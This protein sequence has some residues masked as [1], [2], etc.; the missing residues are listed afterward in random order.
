MVS[1]KVQVWLPV[2]FAVLMVCG[3]I[4][5]YELRDKTGGSRFLSAG[6]RSSLQEVLDLV[7]ERY[8]DAIPSDSLGQVAI[9]EVLDHLDPHSV[10]IPAS[11]L[12]EMDE[13]LEGNFQGIGIEFQLIRD[14][15]NIVSIISGG[16]SEKAGLQIGD[17]LLRAND[18]VVLAGVN[19]TTD[20]IRRQLRGAYDSP[21]KLTILRNG[22][23][24]QVTIKRGMIHLLMQPTLLPRRQVIYASTNLQSRLT[25]NS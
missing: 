17:Q 22:Q 24:K 8:V 13:Q 12:A 11:N 19:I 25:W 3:M 6:G 4:I 20:G 10:Y 21:V 2:L 5:G 16:P 1:K 14:T 9:S 23:Q 15:V 18:T 7:K